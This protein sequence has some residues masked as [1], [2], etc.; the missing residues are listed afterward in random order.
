MPEFEI[1]EMPEQQ[2]AVVKAT[3]PMAEL[4]SIFD[5]GF[6]VVFGTIGKQRVPPAGA[7]IGYY[8]VKPT[9][10]GVQVEVGV[11]VATPFTAEGDVVPSTLPGGRVVHGTH[12]GPYEQLEQTYSELI[13]WVQEQGHTLKSGMWEC[14]LSDPAAEPDPAKWRTEIYWPIE[15]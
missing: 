6:G 8:P 3:V 11:P 12:V 1:V 10:E 5:R 7:P 9:D 4:R 15:D 2:T 14:Y 13:Q